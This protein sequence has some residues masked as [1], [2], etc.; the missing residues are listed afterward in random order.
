VTGINAIVLGRMGPELLM[1][2]GIYGEHMSLHMTDCCRKRC[3]NPEQLA[4]A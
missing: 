3:L 2:H 4:I 1:R